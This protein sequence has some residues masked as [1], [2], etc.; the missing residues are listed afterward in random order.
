[1]RL[2]SRDILPL[3]NVTDDGTTTTTAR[4]EK[5]RIYEGLILNALYEQPP[6]G[7]ERTIHYAQ[8]YLTEEPDFPS[9]RI[10]AYLAAAYGQQYL[11][12][13]ESGAD[14]ATVN[15]IRGNALQ[16]VAQALQTDAEIKPILQMLWNPH[17][18]GKSAEE[19]DLEVFYADEAFERLLGGP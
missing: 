1:M 5:R 11:S 6:G 18:P 7:F 12:M 19:N 3:Q 16:A 13:Q 14:E 2:S 8:R 17:Y 9:A 4:P 10:F 15:A